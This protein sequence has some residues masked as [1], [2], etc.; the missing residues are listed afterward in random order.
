VGPLAYRAAPAERVLAGVLPT[1]L[2]RTRKARVHIRIYRTTRTVLLR[3]RMYLYTSCTSRAVSCEHAP[4]RLGLLEYEFSF[5][6]LPPARRGPAPAGASNEPMSRKLMTTGIRIEI[7]IPRT[8]FEPRRL[9]IFQ[10]EPR[11]PGIPR[12][13]DYLEPLLILA[14]SSAGVFFSFAGCLA[15]VKLTDKYR[16]P[17]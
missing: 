3:Y 14:K 17:L 5:V 7:P 4:P 2:A 1:R 15:Y 8:G 6:P 13:L 10:F 11:L 12:L 9:S 16:A